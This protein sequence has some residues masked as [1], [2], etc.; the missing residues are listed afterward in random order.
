MVLDRMT[1]ATAA[2]AQAVARLVLM[3][4]RVGVTS[5]EGKTLV[6]VDSG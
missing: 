2:I 1:A 3:R 6:F 5:M 4:S